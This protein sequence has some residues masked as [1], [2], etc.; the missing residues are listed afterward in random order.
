[1]KPKLLMNLLY[2]LS[3][4]RN[5][6]SSL[7]AVGIGQLLTDAILQLILIPE[8]SLRLDYTA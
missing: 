7:M 4:P 2:N 6:C 5:L 1:M 3:N 8:N